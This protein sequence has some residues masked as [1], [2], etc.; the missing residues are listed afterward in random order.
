MIQNAINPLFK[1][2]PNY[3]SCW[4]RLSLCAQLL[5]SG[6]NLIIV[7]TTVHKLT[8]Q[9]FNDTN[10]IS[11][12]FKH[13]IGNPNYL[14]CLSRISLYALMLF[15]GFKSSFNILTSFKNL[16]FFFTCCSA[17]L[18]LPYLVKTP[19]W[20][21]DWLRPDRRKVLVEADVALDGETLQANK[22]FNLLHVPSHKPAW[23]H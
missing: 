11:P 20:W 2:N 18:S 1:A 10:T 15:S 12:F 14:S 23:G 5:F 21:V 13:V 3:L 17:M 16:H 9:Y 7:S 6:F 19:Y 22:N 4:F 8:I